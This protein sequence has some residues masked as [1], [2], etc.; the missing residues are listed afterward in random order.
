MSNS[1]LAGLLLATAFPADLLPLVSRAQPLLH[2]LGQLLHDFRMQPVTPQSTLAFEA[3][4][5]QHLRS[6]GLAVLDYAFNSLEPDDPA[7]SP[8]RFGAAGTT[9]RR[10]NLKSP[11]TIGT[12]F[13]TLEL[14]RLLYEPLGSGPCAFPLEQRLGI[15][16]GNATP[17][18]AQCVGELTA[19][20]TQRAVLRCLE[21]D[22]DVSW[23]C[24]TLR[25]VTW[26]VSGALARYREA[27]QVRQVLEWLQQAQKSRGRH[28]PVLAVGR[29][30]VNAPVVEDGPYK[31]AAVATVTVFDRGGKRLGTVYLGRMPQEKQQTLSQQLTSLLRAVLEQWQGARPRLAYIADAGWCMADYFLRVL[32]KM[33][34]PQRPGHRLSWERVLDYFHA[35]G[36]ITKL[37]EA[38]FGA[39]GPAQQWARRMRHLLKENRGARRVL[40]AAAYQRNRQQLAGE[41]LA[42]FAGAYAYLQKRGKYMDY[43]RYG[44]LGVPKGSGITEAACKIVVTQ[45]LKQSGM[46]WK[47][48]GGQVILDLRVLCLSG[49]YHQAFCRYMRSQTEKL[50][51]TSTW[52]A[53]EKQRRS[54]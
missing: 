3:A 17:A 4:L 52:C 16:A 20:Q 41:R 53:A 22:H 29:D 9:Y 8:D 6:L 39:G 49:V 2:Q 13:G 35:A 48:P 23:S 45:R 25:K 24:A 21:Q 37:A 43:A 36:Y 38:I 47:V 12:L 1:T 34:D 11:N 15:V 10:R 51:H 18:L 5:Q 46:R 30:G 28:L 33:E 14:R 54:A 44:R 19:S 42:A 27:A 50:G 26:E 40:Q 32:R 31:E 7:A